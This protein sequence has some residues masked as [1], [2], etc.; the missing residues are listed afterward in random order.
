MKKYTFTLK[1]NNN[2]INNTSSCFFCNAYPKST[3]TLDDYIN[4]D[5]MAKNSWL[6]G[7]TNKKT[8]K[9][10][11]DNPTCMSN[12][13]SYFNGFKFSNDC[14]YIED[15]IYYLADGTPFYFT[16]DYITIG[17]NTYYF[18]E[19]GNPIFISGLTKKMKKTIATIYIDG[20]KIT[21]KK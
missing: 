3:K 1:S 8:I 15:K 9:I 6:Y 5:I 19:F 10:N 17:F 14:P 2:N 7:D 11:I 13:Y 16:K 20:L 12:I 18:Y 4:D 21:I